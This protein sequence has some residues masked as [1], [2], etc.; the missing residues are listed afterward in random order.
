MNHPTG[1]MNGYEYQMM[2]IDNVNVFRQ[3]VVYVHL[4]LLVYT[5]LLLLFLWLFYH[6]VGFVCDSAKQLVHW[7]CLATTAM[8]VLAA[9]LMLTSFY[10]P[11]GLSCRAVAR[12]LSLGFDIAMMCTNAYLLECVYYALDRN[13]QLLVLGAILLMLPMPTFLLVFGQTTSFA[14]LPWLGCSMLYSRLV[15]L[16]KLLTSLPVNLLFIAAF[17]I[18]ARREYRKRRRNRW[19]SLY[20]SGCVCVMLLVS[21]DLVRAMLC[22]LR[23]L[24]F[25]TNTINLVYCSSELVGHML[26]SATAIVLVK[27]SLSFRLLDCERDLLLTL[28]EMK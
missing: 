9:S 17:G 12:V 2:H 24:V 22:V 11:A 13:R 27:I 15:I 1:D 5:V 7:C 21:T 28:S 20:R 16:I 25:A 14:I 8:G 26:V 23:P 3:R 10:S 18:V 4:Q 6:S 19:R